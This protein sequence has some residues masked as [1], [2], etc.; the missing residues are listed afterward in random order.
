LMAMELISKSLSIPTDFAD[1]KGL[2]LFLSTY[3][4]SQTLHLSAEYRNPGLKN[5]ETGEEVFDG[6]NWCLFSLEFNAVLNKGSR[7]IRFN[8][9]PSFQSY[10][11]IEVALDFAPFLSEVG[12]S[13][14]IGFS[15]NSGN[16][17]NGLKRFKGELFFVRLTTGRTL[18][19]SAQNT[20]ELNEVWDLPLLQEEFLHFADYPPNELDVDRYGLH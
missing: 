14:Q 19:H 15:R 16:L 12:G 13:R 10:L 20:D 6:K 7:E 9:K 4:S 8:L 18:E 17:N 5:S 11:K 3:S 2:G 1:I